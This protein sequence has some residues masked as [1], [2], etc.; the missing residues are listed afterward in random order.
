MD[1]NFKKF[2]NIVSL[3]EREGFKIETYNKYGQYFIEFETTGLRVYE[4]KKIIDLLP[5]RSVI[6]HSDNGCLCVNTMININ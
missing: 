3:I 5:I 6:T 2:R 4:V 1:E